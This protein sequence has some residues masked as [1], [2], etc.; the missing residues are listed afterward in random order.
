MKSPQTQQTPPWRLMV[1][2]CITA[3]LAGCGS[4]HHHSAAS[5]SAATPPPPAASAPSST[6]PPAPK[7]AAPKAA[8]YTQP[9]WTT[10]TSD[11][12]PLRDT[13]DVMFYYYANT[14][15][16]PN[17]KTI[18]S[19]FDRHY[20]DTTDV[21]TKHKIIKEIRPIV[22][23]KIATAKAH[24]YV[25]WPMYGMSLGTYSFKRHGFPMQGTML[26]G[27]GYVRYTSWRYEYFSVVLRNTQDFQ[28]LTVKNRKLAE[29]IE[30]WLSSGQNVYVRP[31]LF[32][33]GA[34]L[35]HRRVKAV[36]T[37]IEIFGPQKQLLM[38]YTPPHA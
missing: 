26:L 15:V 38:T 17:Y 3:G 33:N 20:M 23:R 34:S 13:N 21:F 24:P 31:Y 25:Y 35:D 12:I 19:N 32:V 27:G 14:G 16:S 11:Y 18:A 22:D 6:P 7:P 28:F 29:K 2:L 9:D 1:A 36:A 10:P 8:A 37:K 30:H 5:S 4:S